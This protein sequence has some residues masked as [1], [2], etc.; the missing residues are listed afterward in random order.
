M[1]FCISIWCLNLD[2]RP[3]QVTWWAGGTPPRTET[4][5]RI[6]VQLADWMWVPIWAPYLPTR[7][8]FAV[9]YSNDSP[10]C[11][12]SRFFSLVRSP[13]KSTA[14][15]LLYDLARPTFLSRDAAYSPI[16]TYPANRLLHVRSN[17]FTRATKCHRNR[18]RSA[19]VVHV[20]V[21]MCSLLLN[22]E[23]LSPS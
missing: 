11:E 3:V 7:L 17:D 22:S 6:R 23:G 5:W 14:S 4:C 20:L 9:L 13:F 15:L 10:L 2:G 19:S 12:A 21:C 18:F 8:L 16:P 1:E